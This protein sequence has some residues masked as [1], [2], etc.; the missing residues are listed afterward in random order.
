M[1][2]SD[3]WTYWSEQV[4]GKQVIREV[5]VYGTFDNQRERDRVFT[6]FR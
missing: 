2:L 3:N 5:S 4:L 1:K 6:K